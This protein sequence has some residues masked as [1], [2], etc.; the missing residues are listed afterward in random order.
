MSRK[1]P[2][3]GVP[4]VTVI[5]LNWN[6]KEDTLEC[7]GSL[8]RSEY[9]SHRIIVVDNGSTDGS[10]EV[11]RAQYPSV[12]LVE[13]PA[14]V[15]FAAGNNRGIEAA[16]R[17]DTDVVF[18]LNNDTTVAPDCL[19]NLAQAARE[20]PPGSVLGPKILY[21]DRPETIWHLGGLWDRRRFELTAIGRDEPS[22]KWM[23]PSRV[24]HIVGCAMWIPS[25]VIREVGMFDERFFL[26]YE[27]TD[28]CFRAGRAGIPIFVVPRA[29]VWHK[30]SSSFSSSAQMVYFLE[31]NR[32]LWIEKN[33][34]GAEKWRFVARKEFA[35]KV[36]ILA[37][38]LRRSVAYV[39]FFLLGRRRT[40]ERT[41]YKLR[42]NYAA[43]LAWSHYVLRRFGDCPAHIRK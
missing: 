25:A 11:F 36:K 28:W 16:L 14:N 18:L 41:R 13:L 40:L 24:D 35:P 6:G 38:L 34:K 5:V 20:L 42:L 8:V 17:E 1:T 39:L 12:G 23:D 26:N 33:F 27:E 9:P 22:G 4:R 37:R 10:A 21:Y 30:V 43:V 3:Q 29:R 15:G 2:L 7:L 19:A 31:R 32:L